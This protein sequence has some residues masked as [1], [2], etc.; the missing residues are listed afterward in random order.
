[1]NIK[2]GVEGRTGD[3]FAPQDKLDNLLQDEGICLDIAADRELQIAIRKLMAELLY[4][5]YDLI[6]S[7]EVTP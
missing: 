3:I 2:V 5:D 7:I 1:M 6:V 4:Q